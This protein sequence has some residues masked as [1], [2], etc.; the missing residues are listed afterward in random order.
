M[1]KFMYNGIK[2]DGKL[3]KASYG[4]GEY[5]NVNGSII[6]QTGITIYA[7]DYISFPKIEGLTIKNESDSMTDYFETDRIY[8]LPS[9]KY[10]NEINL[11][12]EKQ[13]EKVKILMEKRKAKREEKRRK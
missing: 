3:Y 7:R 2:L 11:A 5:R 13:E 1:L 6:A 12:W 9:N 10:W 8:V 4:K